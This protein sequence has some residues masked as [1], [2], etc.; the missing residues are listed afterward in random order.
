MLIEYIHLVF[1]PRQD[2]F[3]FQ[4][5]YTFT[6]F[7]GANVFV[8]NFVFGAILSFKIFMRFIALKKIFVFIKCSYNE[9]NGG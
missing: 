1:D 6:Y 4:I 3:H 7:L 9:S 8:L 5:F 2:I